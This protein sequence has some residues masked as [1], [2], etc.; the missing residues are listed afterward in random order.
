MTFVLWI[1]DLG[2]YTNGQ[3]LWSMQTIRVIFDS[4]RGLS[5]KQLMRV[6]NVQI[7]RY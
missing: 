1:N 7:G 6:N 2:E 3:H 4:I 5:L